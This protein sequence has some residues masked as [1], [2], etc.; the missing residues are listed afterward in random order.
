MKQQLLVVGPIILLLT[1]GLSGCLSDPLNVEREKFVGSWR[2]CGGDSEFSGFICNSDK[3]GT[4]NGSF[5]RWDIEKDKFVVSGKTT[6]SYGYTFD[7]EN[8]FLLVLNLYG[9]KRDYYFVREA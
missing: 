7:G 4:W 6:L 2:Y 3:T 1:V 9:S 5:I 8:D